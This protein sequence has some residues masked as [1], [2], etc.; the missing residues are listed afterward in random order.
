MVSEPT[1]L[2]GKLCQ[3][4]GCGK[5]TRSRG[6]CV[7]CYYRLL[8]RGTLQANT[9][10]DKKKHV[11][12]DIDVNSRTARCL[13]C[14]PTHIRARTKTKPSGGVAAK[15]MNVPGTINAHTVRA[16]KQCSVHRVKYVVTHMT[17]VGTTITKPDNIVAR[18]AIPAIVQLVCSKTVQI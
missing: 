16:E 11:L 3:T 17:Y 15:Q 7:A 12:V 5:P 1:K 18:C 14:G 4:V 6:F 13:A 10:T 9:Q 2:D 8:R